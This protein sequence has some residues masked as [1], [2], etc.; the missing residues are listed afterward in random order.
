MHIFFL[1][2]SE[3]IEKFCEAL[4]ELPTQKKRML[5]GTTGIGQA[6]WDNQ[7]GDIVSVVHAPG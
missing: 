4:G 2:R 3:T 7:V 5:R 1:P 6:L